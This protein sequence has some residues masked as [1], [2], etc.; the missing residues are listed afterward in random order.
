MAYRR[1]AMVAGVLAALLGGSCERS[2]GPARI[3]YPAPWVGRAVGR[4]A[5]AAIDA[6]GASRVA[7]LPGATAPD[8]P[9]ARGY[10]GDVAYAESV[11]TTPRLAAAVGPQSSLATLL[12]A[13]VYAEA[14]IPL[15]AATAT[16]DSLDRPPWVF[17]LAPKSA[18]EGAFIARFVLERLGARRV[19]LFYLDSDEYGLSLRDGVVRALLGRGVT[20]ADQVGVIET[21]DF[22]RRVDES[23]RRTVPDAVVVAARSPE[24]ARILRALR[25]RLRN[26]PV[27][28]GDGVLLDAPFFASAGAA[29]ADVYAVA[30]WDPASADPRSRDF[31]ERFQ[32]TA[33]R[34][35]SPA[36]AM[37]YDAIMVVAEAVREAGPRP[38]A[39]R[40]WLGALGTTH[41]PFDGVTGPISFSP[42]RRVNLRMM[43]AA[44]GAAAAV[45]WPERGR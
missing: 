17:Q 6:W 10:A 5:Q 27:V 7:E 41:P 14:G 21:A 36:D 33:H 28:A 31:A 26:V 18:V 4:V 16:S 12:V 40:R 1:V 19:T 3:A 32:R 45:D 30:W 22:P 11:V 25:A 43:Q 13:P 44:G 29:A 20:P 39:V 42:D 9:F 35:P 23:L 2:A 34:T 15:I 37:F 24:A 38:E 8:V